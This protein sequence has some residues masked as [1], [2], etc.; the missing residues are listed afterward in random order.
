[1]MVV[2][3]AGAPNTT[4][5]QQT[6]TVVPNTNYQFSCWLASVHPSSPAQLQFFV[7]NVQIGPVF[8]ATAVNCNWNMFFNQWFSGAATSA[9][10]AIRNQ[11]TA[12]AG[13]D[14]AIDDIW[15]A[16]V[17]QV[18]DSHLIVVEDPV[19][20]L[21]NDTAA[22]PG[23]S[24]LLDAGTGFV[25]YLWSNGDVTPQ[26]QIAAGNAAWVRVTTDHGCIATDT[27]DVNNLPLPHIV[28]INDSICGGDTATLSAICNSA[29]S[30]LWSNGA[31]NPSVQVHPTATKQYTVLV[32][33]TLGCT[34]SAIATVYLLPNPTVQLSPDVTIC[35]GTQ[36]TLTASGGTGFH[37][38]PGGQNTDSITVTPQDPSTKYI[39]V[40]TDHNQCRDSAEVIVQTI[41]YPNILI[42]GPADTLC[43]GQPATINASGGDTYAW[44]TGAL[45]PTI[46]VTP[47][48][49]TTYTVTVS[50]LSGGIRCET[51]ARYHL[52][53]KPCNVVFVPNAISL[54]GVNN[55]FKPQG[56]LIYAKAYRLLIF[57]RWGQL[58]FESTD[59]L[60]GWDG[61]FRGN[62]VQEGVYVYDILIDS[63]HGMPWRRRGTLTVI[64]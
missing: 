64:Q 52:P 24:V 22:C 3:G 17:V 44:N 48:E 60:H 15:F 30:F 50:I 29:A 8:T 46:T 6:I 47:L 42:T 55:V 21:G 23:D 16:Q 2:N 31:G 18:T 20:N 5:W 13:N 57:N 10:I 25:Q 49:N 51:D 4:I 43:I 33:D 54:S 58:M 41:P 1:M 45:M 28:T 39:V 37:W 53:V 59:F 38:L 36:T 14:F 19:I 27:L 35:R 61:T 26:T 9:V 34:D 7:N 62:K 56:E 63:G 11:N 12:L 32:T 40:V